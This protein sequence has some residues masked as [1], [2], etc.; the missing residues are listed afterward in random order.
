[1]DDDIE[2]LCLGAGLG[3]ICRNRPANDRGF[4]HGGVAVVYRASEVSL[5][6]VKLHNPH[7]FEV[8]MATGMLRGC[9]RRVVVVAS[10]LPPNYSVGRG[11]SAMEFTAGAVAEA[12]R[13]FDDPLLI[14]AGDYNQWGI[15]AHLADFP[16]LEEY[17]VG[18]TR[19][20]HSIDKIFSNMGCPDDVGTVPPLETDHGDGVLPWQGRVTTGSP[21]LG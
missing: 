6:R 17:Q 15:A 18:P 1:M 10:Y 9:A 7:N 5:R 21:S 16:D 12:K 11:R 2:D 19:A 13:R 4:S 14:V 20:G 3:M 8:I